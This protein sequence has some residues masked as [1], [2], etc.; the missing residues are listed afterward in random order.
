MSG[1]VGGNRDRNGVSVTLENDTRVGSVVQE[2]S[3][4]GEKHP[5]RRQKRR[6]PFHSNSLERR[7]TR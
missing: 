2:T 5:K 6:H 1:V 7:N 3:G 4:L